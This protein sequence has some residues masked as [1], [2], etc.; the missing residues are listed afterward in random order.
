[1]TREATATNRLMSITILVF[2]TQLWT[3]LP[4]VTLAD[5]G[6]RSVAK[7]LI[8]AGHAP[9]PDY[10]RA[11]I[12]TMERHP[13]DG[14][15]F[16]LHA[17][18][19]RYFFQPR[20]LDPKEFE[21]DFKDL[22][23]IKWE[24]FTDNFILVWTAAGEKLD[25]FNDEHWNAIEHNMQL[26]AKAARLGRCGIAL[27]LE[28]YLKDRTDGVNNIWSYAVAP[29]RSIKSFA[30]YRAMVHRRGRRFIQVI[31]KEMPHATIFTY[32]H[33]SILRKMMVAG[34][35]SRQEEMLLNEQYALV[36]A[37]I[38]GMLEASDSQVR[39]IDGNEP[40]YWYQSRQQYL[41]AYHLLTDR[42]RMFLDRSL[43]PAFRAHGSIGQAVYIDECFATRQRESLASYMSPDER[44][45]FLEHNVYWA[46]YTADEYAWCFDQA[47][48]WWKSRPQ[49]TPAWN[50]GMPLGCEAA[51][52]A[53][54][55][56]I[57][58][59]QPLG[60]DLGPIIA[61]AHRRRGT[62]Q[63]IQAELDMPGQ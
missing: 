52:S 30:E 43:W 6:I 40:A 5:S 21:A 14:L 48:D 18:G 4:A 45:K 60:F 38:G 50:K 24:K 7:K 29:H 44:A 35:V 12:R 61:S 2:L 33:M 32:F 56:K 27:D 36:P 20:P 54:R 31:Q 37:F 49:G 59:G 47:I 39:I 9:L 22:Q 1:M 3:V 58:S 8:K 16:R 53:A 10:I 41:T 15:V 13:F 57:A 26:V 17:A 23:A 63:R 19:G 34:P 46:L 55:R 28:T 51:I 62:A 11:H 25:W 42:G